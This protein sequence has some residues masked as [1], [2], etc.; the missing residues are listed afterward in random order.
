MGL[1]KTLINKLSDNRL[2][3]IDYNSNELLKIHRMIL[4]EKKMMNEVFSEFYDL[5]IRYEKK[6][7]KGDGIRLEIGAGVSFFKEKYPEIISTDIKESDYLDMSV[8][9]MNMP[10]DNNSI[11]TVY[12]INCFHHLAEPEKFFSEL[13]RCLCK[14]GGCILIEPY[15]GLLASKFYKKLFE[16]EFFD[17]KQKQWNNPDNKIMQGANQALSYIIFKRDQKIFREKHPSLEIIKNKPLSNY[18]R[19]ILS[20]GLNF[21]QL[22][23][24]FLSPL[25]KSLEY[26]LLPFIKIFALHHIIIIRK[27]PE[28]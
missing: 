13:E 24:Q 18:L 23:P 27:N 4:R 9:A 21:K 12:G 5:C 17:K 26:I 10:F 2:K 8:D 28:Q 1:F 7:L 3:N 22:G 16:T 20:G 6:Y 15:Y 25:I 11:K 19:Y 14:G